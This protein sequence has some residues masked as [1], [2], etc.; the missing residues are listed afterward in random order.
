MHRAGY[1]FE[2]A[3]ALAALGSVEAAADAE[4]LAEGFVSN[5]VKSNQNNVETVAIYRANR[6]LPGSRVAEAQR[7]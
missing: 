3:E 4:T 6:K 7:R 1:F 2:S 5:W